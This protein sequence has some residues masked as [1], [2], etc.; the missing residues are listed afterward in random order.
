[1]LQSLES[2]YGVGLDGQEISACFELLFDSFVNE[3]LLIDHLIIDTVDCCAL[4]RGCL[5][6][7]HLLRELNGL[8]VLGF[9]R[10]LN[11]GISLLGET[12]KQRVKLG[13]AHL[14]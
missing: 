8:A 10:D 9:F 5:T 7:K 11:L 14:L 6:H 3:L 12:L 2:L 4:L 13:E 1:M